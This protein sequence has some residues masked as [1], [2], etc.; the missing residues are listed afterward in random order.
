M[1]DIRDLL[2]R[3]AGPAPA[4]D[5]AAVARDAH[6]RSVT[7]RATAGVA[8]ALLVGAAVAVGIPALR[9]ATVYEGGPDEI[10]TG[11]LLGPPTP[12]QPPTPF[13]ETS[14]VPPDGTATAAPGE[15]L[16]APLPPAPIAPRDTPLSVWTGAEMVVMGGFTADG[17][18]AGGDGAAYDPTTNTWRLIPPP[19]GDL[20]VGSLFPDGNGVLVVGHEAAASR[21][22][23][24]AR[25]DLG[26]QE[27]ATLPPVPL[28]PRDTALIGFTGRHLAIFGGVASLEPVTGG[29]SPSQPG[30][31]AVYDTETGAWRPIAEVPKAVAFADGVTALGGELVATGLTGG[32][33]WWV[34][35]PEADDWRVMPGVPVRSDFALT[36]AGDDLFAVGTDPRDDFG[37]DYRTF[38]FDA[39]AGTWQDLGLAPGRMEWAGWTGERLVT[40]PWGGNTPLY[41]FDPEAGQWTVLPSPSGVREGDA[42][43]LGGDLAL[44]WSGRDTSTGWPS[45]L[46][47]EGARML[48]P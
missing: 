13:P 29:D 21:Q 32:E 47:P 27:W 40:S 25:Y 22:L 33:E 41:A 36:A 31:G 1:P 9:P 48:L 28:S 37:A 18:G 14:P 38:R 39:A 17:R 46:S 45:P 23:A 12:T 44:S 7:R 8:A 34:Y 24:V 6:R 43:V 2:N 30:D 5:L 4:A 3:A 20:Q 26:R 16:V 42:L 15:A 11:V 35:D 19:P 10:P